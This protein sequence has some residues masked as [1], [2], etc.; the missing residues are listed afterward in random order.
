[1][2]VITGDKQETAINIGYSSRLLNQGAPIVK[3]NA[4]TS[5]VCGELLDEAL[6]TYV[7]GAVVKDLDSG[8]TEEHTADSLSIVIDGN[9]LQF[10]LDDHSEAFLQLALHASAVV[11]W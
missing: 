2:W 6:R 7:R 4:T 8:E 9:T 1:M 11:C 3:L 10:A 5:E